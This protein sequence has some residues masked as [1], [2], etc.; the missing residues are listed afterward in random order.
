M[1]KAERLLEKLRACGSLAVGLSGGVDSAMLAKAAVLALGD[2]AV[3]ITASSELL[4]Q[5]EKEDAIRC[6]E[7]IGIRHQIIEAHDLDLPEVAQNGKER[8][9]YCKKHRF[10]KIISWA[11][12]H[13]YRYVADGSNADDAGDYRP[14]ERAVRELHV[15]SPLAECGFTKKDIRE[16]A[17]A[18]GIPLWSKPSAACLASRVAYGIPLTPE[19][20]SRIDQAENLL[21]Q[22]INGQL[23]LRDHGELAR[24][25]LMP[26]DF[27]AFW[28]HRGELAQGIKALGYAYVTLDLFGYRMG[29]TNEVI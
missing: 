29:S 10:Q 27:E 16:Q 24:I 25:E 28:A 23:R 11:A 8:C 6:A 20:L 3:A 18:W 13:G 14:G 5:A 15:L 7:L 2:K 26:E 21:R 19:R 12:E 9:Y 1:D 17:K 4:P 22:Y